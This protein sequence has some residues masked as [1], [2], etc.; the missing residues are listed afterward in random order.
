[1]ALP[2][3][4]IVNMKSR[5]V[6]DIESCCGTEGVHQR[7]G[8][9]HQLNTCTQT[10]GVDCGLHVIRAAVFCIWLFEENRFDPQDLYNLCRTNEQGFLLDRAWWLAVSASTTRPFI[11]KKRTIVE[12]PLSGDGKRSKDDQKRTLDSRQADDHGKRTS[13][14]C[15]KRAEVESPPNDQTKDLGIASSF[16]QTPMT[17]Y[18]ANITGSASEFARL[19]LRHP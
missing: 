5:L 4:N 18:A 10:G 15:G 17:A 12:S 8:H 2:S 3:A 11:Q 14:D 19:P 6:L 13:H 9:N 16:T 1:M 7:S